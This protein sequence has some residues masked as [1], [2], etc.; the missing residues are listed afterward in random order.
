MPWDERGLKDHPV[1]TSCHGQGCPPPAQA[2][3]GPIQ[4][5]LECLQTWGIHCPLSKESFHLTSNN[6]NLPFSSLKPFPLLL[7]LSYHVKKLVYLLF[8]SLFSNYWWMSVGTIFSTWRNSVPYH[9]SIHTA[10][11][12]AILSGYPSA[13]IHH[14]AATY[15]GT[16]VGRFSLY[17][18]YCVLA[19][20]L[21]G[22]SLH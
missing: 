21:V 7:S 4:P 17:T 8:I 12:D 20:E 19:E 16:L 10:T 6:L 9:C 1:L 14:M 3:Q 2:A 18:W 5:G 11:S 13:A 15:N 22:S